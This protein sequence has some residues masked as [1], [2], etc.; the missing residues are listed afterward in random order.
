MSTRARND[1]SYLH[2]FKFCLVLHIDNIKVCAC[3]FLTSRQ[4]NVNLKI[5]VT[6]LS[7][8]PNTIQ[9][10]VVLVV[11]W[12]VPSLTDQ[13]HVVR[14]SNLLFFLEFVAAILHNE[15]LVDVPNKRQC[16]LGGNEMV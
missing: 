11:I 13:R 3:G 10:L 7:G 4:H 12:K 8:I 2:T 1:A 16:G 15:E 14:I 6:Y 5:Q 9:I